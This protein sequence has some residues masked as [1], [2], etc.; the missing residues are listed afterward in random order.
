[1]FHLAGILGMLER[2]PFAATWLTRLRDGLA[3]AGKPPSQRLAELGRLLTWLDSRRNMAFAVIAPFLLTTTRVGLAVERWRRH[4]GPALGGWL[5]AVGEIEAVAS[6]ANYAAENPSDPFPEI[7]ESGPLFDAVGLGHPLLP[8]NRC[9]RNDLRL[10]DRL[11]LLVVSGSNMSGK[12]TFLRAAGANTVMA[13]AGAPVRAERLR[14]SPLAVGATLRIQDSLLEGKSRFY[15]EIGRLRRI[16]ELTEGSLPVF[17]LLDEILAGTNSHDRRIGAEAVVRSLI[18]R[19]AIGMVTTH[20]LALTEIAARLA[21]R[22]VNV[23]FAD[24]MVGGELHFDYQL[25]AGPVRHSNALALMRAVGLEVGKPDEAA[26]L[27]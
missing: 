14:L 17:F 13:L 27:Q 8:A 19:P 4:A 21:P 18:Q 26:P 1:L 11:R 16:V 9:V 2:G 7:V 25:H 23:H 6:L 24:E 20:D 10:D 22:A 3:V 12:S 5:T 15:A